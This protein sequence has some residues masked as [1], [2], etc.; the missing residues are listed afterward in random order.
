[1]NIITEYSAWFILVCL[2]IGVTFGAI[3]YFRNNNDELPER[4]KKWLFVIRSVAVA[5]IAFLLLGPMIK[6]IASKDLKP[7][8]VIATDA[9]LSMSNALNDNEQIVLKQKTMELVDEL[10]GRF[11]VQ[12]FIFGS[13]VE[14]N[15]CDSFYMPLTDMANLFDELNIQYKNSNLGAVV[16]ISDGINNSGRDPLYSASPIE[17]SLYAIGVGDTTQ[18]VDISISRVV[19]NKTTYLKNLFP[20]QV[21]VQGEMSGGSETNLR[22]KKNDQTLEE[23]PVS[24]SSNRFSSTFIFY[25]NAD[26]IGFHRYR[27]ELDP[28]I[29]EENTGNNYKEVV[30]EVLDRKQRA[31]ILADAPHPDVGA[32][33][34]I[35]ETASFDVEHGIG[36]RITPNLEFEQFDIVILH[37]LPSMRFQIDSIFKKCNDARIPILFVLGHNTNF[38]QF[39]NLQTGLSITPQRDLKEE[40]LPVRNPSFSSFL[41]DNAAIEDF[42]KWGPLVTAFGDYKAANSLAILFYQKIGSVETNYPLMAFNATLSGKYGF[43]CGEGLWRWRMDSERRNRNSRYVDELITKSAQLLIS[44]E[45][46]KR[47]RIHVEKEF[48]SYDRIVFRAELYNQMQEPVAG[49]EV[50]L[51]IKDEQNNEYDYTFG[52]EGINYKLDAGTFAP[53]IY[54]WAVAAKIGMENF[55][56]R[57]T[58]TILSSMIEME[59]TTAN[60][61]LLMNLAHHHNGTFYP[62]NA[63]SNLSGDILQRN[64]LKPMRITTTDFFP[65]TNIKWLLFATL[66]LLFV[67]WFLRKF[68]G[69]Y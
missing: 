12:Q 39:N 47:L 53:G 11:D 6:Q 62:F 7:T 48:T 66:L 50:K 34:R 45:K 31:L 46:S 28:I 29:R 13:E 22:I 43:I 4:L 25:L 26:S 40:S 54:Q 9:S 15:P 20:I 67:E 17:A 8:V 64:D 55:A 24:I 60:H 49:E 57:G 32:L 2:I 56:E 14:N 61:H 16:L 38:P 3:L 69:S 36:N 51:V 44:D 33:K 18:K 1:L 58:F 5:F 68:F 42:S 10:S 23:R 21:T 41:L 59:Q 37:S 63:I 27:L 65:L 19:F 52:L 30:V 35:L